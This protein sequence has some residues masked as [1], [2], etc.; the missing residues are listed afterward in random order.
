MVESVSDKSFKLGKLE[1]FEGSDFCCW[2]KK[3]NFL[4]STLK[5]V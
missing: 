5:V 4:L 1:K 2:Q 3:I